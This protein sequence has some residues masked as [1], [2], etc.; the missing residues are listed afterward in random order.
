ME[1][2]APLLPDTA[3]ND[4]YFATRRPLK[5]CDPHEVP[6]EVLARLTGGSGA[7]LRLVVGGDAT[8]ARGSTPAEDAVADGVAAAAQAALAGSAARAMTA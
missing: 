4:R 6:G 2:L 5:L 7:P 1:R 8:L 3:D